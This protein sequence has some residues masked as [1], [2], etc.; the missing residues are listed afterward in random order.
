M[1][2]E[3]SPLA[4]L[5]YALAGG[6]NTPL[7]IAED[8]L[9]HATGG[10]ARNTYLHLNPKALLAQAEALTHRFQSM[11]TRPPL[12]GI[13]ISLKDCFDLAGT[14][15][16][17]GTRFYQQRHS[18]ATQNSAVAQ[19]LLDEGC[20]LTGKTHLHPLAYGITGENPDFGDCLQPADPALLTGGS[21]S[22]AAASVQ[23]GSAL[24]AIGTDTG[25]S[26]RVPAALCGLCGFRASHTLAMEQDLW[27]GAF[28][29]APSFDTLGL[30]TRDPRDLAPLA[31]TL[32]HIP[33]GP[34]PK[35][36]R[37]GCV[38]ESFL[39]PCDPPVLE[40][41]R[42]FKL[43]L[44][45]TGAA[46]HELDTTPWHD[47]PDI[48]APLQAAEAAAL[49]RGHFHQFETTVAQRLAWG[50]SLSPA[51]LTVLKAR[52][53]QFVATLL[54]LFA[55]ASLLILPCAP[56]SRLLAGAD[57]SGTRSNILR[58]TTP[59]SLVGLPAVALPGAIAGA[60]FGTGLQLAAAPGRDATLLAF[61]ATLAATLPCSSFLH[62][63]PLKPIT[64][65][66]HDRLPIERTP[67]FSPICTV[68]RS[69]SRLFDWTHDPSGILRS[70]I[71]CPVRSIVPWPTLP[72]AYF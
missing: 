19:R 29:L 32:F 38:P 8:V 40:S 28:H 2:P 69:G 68:E 70:Q 61:T 64:I 59:F 53:E 45:Q 30:L 33:D 7:Q 62:D 43:L 65:P 22:G 21:S 60:A 56:V 11:A 57:H 16:T 36:T 41:Y 1:L 63:T 72:T 25:G 5:Q 44:A 49:H 54:A 4:A 23:E 20:L 26:I 58:Y 15:T 34:L 13:P 46:L 37:I 50:E 52:R 67:P 71:L 3:R 55:E 51:E 66:R 39:A 24:V 14:R 48:F 42:R 10:A 35:R 27:R 9:A 12:Y 17:C 31:Q 47:A 18:P 6:V